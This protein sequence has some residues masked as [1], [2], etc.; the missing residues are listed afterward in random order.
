[1]ENNCEIRIR[2]PAKTRSGEQLVN[3]PIISFNVESGVGKVDWIND[4]NPN[5][6]IIKNRK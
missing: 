5:S 1:M 2:A 3:V 4:E 6:K